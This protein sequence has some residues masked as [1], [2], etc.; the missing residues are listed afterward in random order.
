MKKQSIFGYILK[1]SITLLLITGIVALA[2]AG[3]NSV[4]APMIEKLNEQKI[5]Q[6]IEAVLPGGGEELDTFT[7][8]TGMVMA[9]Y[10]SDSGYAVKVAPQGFGGAIQMMVGVDKEGKVLGISIISQVETA[11]LGAVIAAKTQKGEDFR[12]QFVGMSG[13]LAVDKD[14]GAIE[15]ITSATISSRAVTVGVN[16]ALACVE[17]LG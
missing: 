16:A 17:K 10:A 2:L 12:S 1:L 9:V 3:V 6:A 4:T 14:G 8:D 13:E 5:Q 7:D 15:A 11:G